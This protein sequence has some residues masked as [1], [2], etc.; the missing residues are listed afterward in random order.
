MSQ[1]LLEIGLEEV[2][3]GFMPQ[4]LAQLKSHM[5]E[6]LK[7]AR[8]DFESVR[9]LGTPRRLAI[10]VDGIAEKQNDLEE[11]VRGPSEKVAYDNEKK[12]TKAL[13][14]FM[15]GNQV[16]E[17]DLVIRD[18]YIYAMRKQV[19]EPTQFVLK[20]LLPELILGLSFPKTM[21]W[22]AWETRYVR[23]IHWIVALLDADVIPFSVEMCKSDRLTRGHRFLGEASFAIASAATYEEQLRGNFVIV[24]QDVRQELI[25]K[26]IS[27]LVGS[28][29]GKIQS[30]AALLEEIVYLVEYP[31]ALMGYYDERFLDMP[32]ELVITPMKEHQRYFPVL[33]EKDGSLLNRFITVRNGSDDHL[34]IVQD[35]NE[36]VLAARLADARFFY[37]EDLKVDPEEW[38]E[39]LK[40]V[41]FQEQLGTTYEKTERNE[42]LARKIA[43]LLRANQDDIERAVRAAHLA[44]ADLVS[45]VVTEFP[46]LQGMIGEVYVNAFGKDDALT[47]QAVREHYLP[48]FA[49]DAIPETEAGRIVAL[50]D[51]LDTI[52][53]CF[54][55]G[56]EPTGSQDPYALRRQASGILSII[57]K[58]EKHISLSSMISL[59]IEG[60]PQH[61]ITDAEE[62]NDKVY[63]FF[64]QRIRTVLRA[65]GYGAVFTE[66]LLRSGYDDP[67]YTMIRAKNIDAYM[68]DHATAF[69]TL[70]VTYKRAHNLASKAENV[71]VRPELFEA[72]A[73]KNLYD[74]IRHAS[75]GIQEKYDVESKL[76]ALQLL[77]AP[78]DR[79]FED[80]MVMDKRI[81]IQ[82]NRLSLLKL[83]TD[84]TVDIIDL[85]VL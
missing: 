74:A 55:V 75:G 13:L 65:Q 48:R 24:D 21:R 44:K 6:A 54:A 12:P 30:D 35:G 10:F 57:L 53:G 7:D 43:H 32:D 84:I 22:G 77:I 70:L 9:S 61:L 80:V 45:N 47:A 81:E 82:Q 58:S 3:A 16:S 39:K 18:Q 59:A 64:D 56:I 52:A 15:K 78:V 4:T 5:E 26:Q 29:G 41:V 51:K 25:E 1:L 63:G 66:A 50:A 38:L 71:K 11:E 73:E 67:Q 46:E 76:D 20:K 36:R 72:E 68:K 19:G 8:I 28:I 2:P 85:S 79:L 17:E 27:Q 69:E 31:T 83:F 62:L 60:L 42:V 34:D 14:G 40:T 33:S 23:P 37:D 49:G